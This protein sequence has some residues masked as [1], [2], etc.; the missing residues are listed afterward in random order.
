MCLAVVLAVLLSSGEEREREL[1]VLFSVS[2]VQLVV[3]GGFVHY[4]LRVSW[5]LGELFF[6]YK[7]RYLEK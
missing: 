5:S 4:F 6:I 2:L 3:G 7:T 1:V